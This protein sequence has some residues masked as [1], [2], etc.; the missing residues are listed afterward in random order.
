MNTEKIVEKILLIFAL[1]A[2]LVIF[3]IILF[4]FKEGLPILKKE[5]LGLESW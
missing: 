4:L 3:L 1:S 2:T 5:G